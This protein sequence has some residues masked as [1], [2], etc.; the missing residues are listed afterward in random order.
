MAMKD[1]V[2]KQV[3]VIEGKGKTI[4]F[5]PVWH[6]GKESYYK[7]VKEHI[8]Y[9]RD[10]GYSIFYEGIDYEPGTDQAT[11]DTLDRKMRKILGY[12]LSSYND[13]NNESQPKYLKNHKYSTQTARNTGLKIGDINADMSINHLMKVYE[14]R[15]GKV[16]LTNCDYQTDLLDKYTCESNQIVHQHAFLHTF[17]NIHLYKLINDSKYS[18]ILVLYGRQH[19]KEISK[20]FDRNGFKILKLKDFINNK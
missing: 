14:S 7:S 16:E 13:Q 15:F 1:T 10:E 5:I 17:R 3:R 12:H 18:K 19:W 2:D 8:D 6:V 11:K 9:F 20:K 4:V